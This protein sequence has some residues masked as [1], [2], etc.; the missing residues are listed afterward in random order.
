V[1]ADKDRFMEIG[2]DK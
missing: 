1:P 2:A